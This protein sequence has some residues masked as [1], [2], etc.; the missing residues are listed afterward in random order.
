M[1]GLIAS[2]ALLA[3]EA[4]EPSPLMPHLSELIVGLVAFA[5]LF[6]F[7]SRTVFPMFEKTYAERTAAIEGGMKRAEEA[8]AEA[9]QA[10][11]DYRRQLADARGEA[12]RIR[13]E[14]R[15]QGAAILAE[16]RE[17]AQAESERITGRAHA[18]IAA[19]REQVVRSLRA[20][21]GTLA[22]QLAGRVVG[23]SLED[24]ARSQRV[25]ER[26]LA[27]LESTQASGNG[28]GPADREA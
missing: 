22:T 9:Q 25:V 2:A 10:L 3:Q 11:E 1:S 5:L 27:E 15:V 28:A 16:M 8:Q 12:S 26:F 23:E 7:L 17:N 13:E 14:A 24:D 6:F 20:E 18:Q 19:E 21:V 4:E